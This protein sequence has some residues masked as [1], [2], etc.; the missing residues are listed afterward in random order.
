MGN[1]A[2]VKPTVNPRG[3]SVPFNVHRGRKVVALLKE[4]RIDDALKLFGQHPSPYGASAL[5]T[6]AGKQQNIDLAFHVYDKLIAAGQQPNIIVMN[7]LISA[8]RRSGSPNGRPLCWTTWT[9]L[10]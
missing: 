10:L 9:G 5:I 8:C 6:S 3:R 2:S 7:A 4:N 1:E